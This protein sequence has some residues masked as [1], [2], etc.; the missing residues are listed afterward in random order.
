VVVEELDSGTLG[1]LDRES[2]SRSKSS[3]RFSKVGSTSELYIQLRRGLV[4]T[5]SSSSAGRV[6]EGFVQVNGDEA[7]PG[8]LESVLEDVAGASAGL[9]ERLSSADRITRLPEKYLCCIIDEAGRDKTGWDKVCKVKRDVDRIAAWATR[10]NSDALGQ[11][12]AEDC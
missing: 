7:A 4:I 10:P 5:A 12:S 6:R 9:G 8:G 11:V 1:R 2:R 3:V